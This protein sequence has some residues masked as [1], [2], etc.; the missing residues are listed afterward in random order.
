MFISD[1]AIRRPII[2]VV[3]MIALVVFGLAS[4]FRLETDEFP[5]LDQPTLIPAHAEAQAD[6]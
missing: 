3:V 2:T 5:E 4:L 6:D 1:F